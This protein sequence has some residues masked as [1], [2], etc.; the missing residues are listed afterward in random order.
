M[1]KLNITILVGAL[2]A[3]L[4]FAIVFGYG[5]NVDQ[6]VADGRETTMVLVAK[7]G[8][9]AGATPAEL[10]GKLV[11]MPVPSA[12]LAEGALTKLDG[13]TGKVLLGP[14]P[15]GGQLS[16]SMF[17][18]PASAGAV[19]PAKG[20]VALAVG[21]SLTP[22]VARYI[23]PGSTV[24]VFVTYGGASQQQGQSSADIGGL[25]KL[26]ASN[27]TV[28]SVSV[29]V[30]P[31]SGNKSRD[32]QANQNAN[33]GGVVVVLDVLPA[34]AEKFV[35]A[36]TLGQLYL[37]L[38]SVDGKGTEHRTKGAKPADVVGSNR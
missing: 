38:S 2:V 37:A 22:G 31:A 28:L 5:R 1:R 3:L 15:K 21:V 34:D 14:L 18:E 7:E 9:L 13:V 35:N 23:T 20:R 17:G 6:R 10:A 30:P 4:G 32:E 12:Y 26:F 24:D 25:T 19:R 36:A 16:A 11:A 33:N 29:A 8:L 27:V